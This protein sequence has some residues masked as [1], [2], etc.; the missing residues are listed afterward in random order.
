[1]GAQAWKPFL[2]QRGRVITS[3]YSTKYYKTWRNL[4]STIQPNGKPRA[5]ICFYLPCILQN[6]EFWAEI[7]HVLWC[8]NYV[9][10]LTAAQTSTLL[11]TIWFWPAN[12]PWCKSFIMATLLRNTSTFHV[13]ID[14][15]RNI[16][17]R[18][19]GVFGT[20]SFAIQVLFYKLP[21]STYVPLKKHSYNFETIY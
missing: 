20:S 7:L 8:T 15:N 18:L 13:K 19:R 17:N 11:K 14:S 9:W 4:H 3:K 1:M 16:P 6:E 12:K 21:S 2:I 10:V 5:V